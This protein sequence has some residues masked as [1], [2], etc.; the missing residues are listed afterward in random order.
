[1]E[2]VWQVLFLCEWNRL[3]N[4][5]LIM[6]KRYMIVQVVKMLAYNTTDEGGHGIFANCYEVIEKD[7]ITPESACMAKNKHTN[8]EHLIVVEYW[9]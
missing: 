6:K 9:V 1:L 5:L 2:T 4:L 3:F 7:Y 8:K